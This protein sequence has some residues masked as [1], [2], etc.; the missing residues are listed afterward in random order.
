M[1]AFFVSYWRYMKTFLLKE[2]FSEE[3]MY[4]AMS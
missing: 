1:C 4:K 2:T 3:P